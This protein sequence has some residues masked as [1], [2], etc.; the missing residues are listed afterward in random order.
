MTLSKRNLVWLFTAGTFFA[1]FLFGFAD[2]LK[3]PTLPALLR[4]LGFSYSQGGT[5]LMAV[6][7]GFLV[8]TLFTGVL[9][10][11]AGQK[12]VLMVAGACLL[13]GMGAYSLLRSFWLLTGAMVVLGLG[14]GALEVG[15]NTV[16]VDLHA[17]QKGRYLNL[18]ALFHGFGSLFAPFYAGQ[19]L[20]AGLSW[21]LV[22]QLGLILVVLLPLYLL[23][24]KYPGSAAA[25]APGT[26]WHNLR[27]SVLTPKMLGFY[28]LVAVYVAAEI[29]LASWLVE[30][31]QQVKGQSVAISSAFL[32]LFFG[33]VMVGRFVGSLLVERVGY[34]KSM[35]IV[36]I[37]A[38]ACL[39]LGILGP[40][41]A[42]V[43]LPLTGLFFSIIFPTATAAVSDLQRENVGTALGLFFAFGGVGGMLGPWLIGVFSDWLGITAGFSLVLV[44]GVM[45]LGTLVMLMLMK[46]EQGATP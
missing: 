46:N 28:V 38:C 33:G 35:L 23:V 37:A 32:S 30:F 5:L 34:L 7:V 19:L 40:P 14:L 25:G 4:D 13:V 39:T 9:A 43:F 41:A 12:T 21:R 16:I 17:E 15:G 1:F 11:S 31:L 42:I 26:D 18:L 3:G 29:G 44:Y 45:T 8:A 22:Y 6:Y 36:S 24:W 20:A 27:Q 2:N 10:D